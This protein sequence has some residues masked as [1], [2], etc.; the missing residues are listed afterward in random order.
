[1][2]SEI[3]QAQKDKY[4]MIFFAYMWS[5]KWSK[6]QKQKVECWLSETG[7]KSKWG[8]TGQSVQTFHC[9]G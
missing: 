6:A 9:V 2:L 3:N 8:D 5:L 4:C 7:E 1:M